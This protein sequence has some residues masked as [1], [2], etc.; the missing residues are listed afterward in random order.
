MIDNLSDFFTWRCQQQPAS[1]AYA[2]IRDDLAIAESLSYAELDAQVRTLAY[3][4]ARHSKPGDRVLL[5]YPPGL[6]FVRAFWACMLTGRIAV[7]VPAP[8]PVRFKNN[9]PRLRA[10]I[11]DAQVSLVLTTSN[12]LESAKSFDDDAGG[13][14]ADWLATDVAALP[15]HDREAANVALGPDSVAYLQYT[16][17]STSTPRGVIITHAQLLAQCQS[18]AWQIRAG[19]S[20]VLSWLPHFHD[21]GLVFGSLMPFHAGVPSTLMSPLSFL[22]RPLRWLEAMARHGATH[23]GAPNFAYMACVKALEQQPHWRADLRALLSCSC[24]AE[25]IHPDAAAQFHAAFRPHGLGDAVFAPAYGM[26]ETVLVITATPPGVPPVTLSLNAERLEQGIVAEGVEAAG[27]VRRVV[28]CGSPIPQMSACIVDPQTLAPSA[29]DRIGEIWVQG[30]SVGQGYWRR[31]SLSAEIFQARTVDGDG[32]Y[33]RTGDMGFMHEGQLFVSSRLKDLII[34]HGRNHAPH[35]IEW[36]V[37]RSNRVLRAGYGAAFSIDS[38]DGEALVVVQEVERSAVDAD[39]AQLIHAIRRAVAEEHDLPVHAVA[40]IRAGTVPRTSSGKIRRQVCKQEYLEAKLQTLLLD[41]TQTQ[42]AQSDPAAEFPADLRAQTDATVRLAAIQQTLLRLVARF[43]RRD[44]REISLDASAIECGLDSL[45]TFRLLQAIESSLGLALPPASVLGEPSLRG[46]AASIDTL[47]G[48]PVHAAPALH[49]GPSEQGAQ[50]LAAAQQRMWF[51]QEMAPDTA[52]YNVPLALALHGPLDAAVLQECLRD[53]TQ[54][55]PILCSRWVRVDGKAMQRVEATAHWSM[56]QV[57]LQGVDAAIAQFEQLAADEGLCALD[58][59]RE[60]PMRATLIRL[61]EDEHRLL[62]TLHHSVCDGWSIDLL[63]EEL[64]EL[65]SARIAR[66]AARLPQLALSYLDYAR[67]EPQWLDSGVREREL[68]YWTRKLAGVP[69]LLHLPADRRRSAVQR[70]R[71]A[72][73]PLTLAAAQ[74]RALRELALRTGTTL[75]MTLLASWQILMHRYSGQ[76]TIV[77]GSVVANRERPDLAGVVG[78]FANTLALRSD[79]GESMSVVDL[80][81]QVKANAL[82]AIDHQHLPFEEVIEALKLPRDTSRM[83][84]IQTMVVLQAPAQPLPRWGEASV[85]RLAL[86]SPI[87]KFDLTLELQEQGAALGGHISFDSDLFDAATV[88]RLA[89]HWLM[90][91]E[92]MCADASQNVATL[93]LL[94][95]AERERILALAH[96]D[97][98]TEMRFV[99]LQRCFEQ[100]AQRTPCAVAALFDDR[101]ASYQEL[102]AQSNRLAHELRRLGVGPDVRVGI[103]M[104]RS[105]ELVAALLGVLKAGGAFVPIDPE[106]PRDRVEF[107]LRD[108]AAPLLLTQSHLL[109]RVPQAGSGA[110]RQ[111]L[112]LDE[113]AVVLTKGITSDPDRES[114][115]HDLAYVIYTSGS[116]G[117]PKGVLIEHAAMH[118]SCRWMCDRLGLQP[119]DRMLAASSISF[120]ASVVEM[121]HPLRAGASVVLARAGAQRDTRALAQ[122]L[123]QQGVTT[124]VMVPSAL[125]A[126][127][128]EASF[129]PARLRFLI[130]AGEALDQTLARALQARLP[131]TTIGNFYGPTEASIVAT[132]CEWPIDCA[133]SAQV[134]IGRPIANAHCLVLDAHLQPVPIGVVGELYIGGAGLARGYL[135]QPAL[136]AERFI[137]HP[138][139]AGQ[140]LYRSGDLARYRSDANIEYLGR[141]DSQ[142]KIRGFRI[143]L[144]EIEAA[145]ATID[146]IREVVVVA[147]EDRPGD[148][149]LVA[150]LVGSG[151]DIQDLRRRLRATLPESMLPAAFVELAEL[152]TLTNGKINRHALPAPEF[153]VRRAEIVAPRNSIERATWEV[154]RDVLQVQQFGVTD[155]FFELGGHSLLAM[156]LISRLRTQL[157]VDL[158]LRTLFDAPTVE[159]LA[160]AIE[161][162][163]GKFDPKALPPIARSPAGPNAPLSAAQQGLWFLDRLQGASARYHIVHALRLRGALDVPALENALQALAARHDSLRMDIVESGGVP[164]QRLRPDVPWALQQHDLRA[165]KPA[166]RESVLQKRL[167][168]FAEAPIALEQAPLARAAVFRLRA[169]E[170]VLALIIHHIV[171]DGWSLQIV[172]RELAAEYNAACASLPSPLEPLVLSWRDV[173]HWDNARRRQGALAPAL[174]YWRQQLRDLEPLRLPLEGISPERHDEPGPVVRTQV[175]GPLAERIEAL[176]RQHNATVFMVLLAAIKVLLMRRCGRDDI[177]VGTPVAGRDRRDFEPLVGLFVNTLVLRTDLGGNPTFEAL[178]G[179]VRSTVLDA[180]AHQELGFDQLVAELAPAREADRQPFFDVMVNSFG[181]WQGVPDMA[182]LTAEPVALPTAQPKFALTVY[183]QANPGAIELCMVARR[184]RFS[185]TALRGLL[186]QLSVLIE[187]VADQPARALRD[188]SMVT[189]SAQALLPDPRRVLALPP[190]VSVLQEFNAQ[191]RQAPA[192]IAVRSDQRAHDYGELQLKSALLARVLRRRGVQRGDVIAICGQRGFAIPAAMLAVL[193]CGAV[194]MILDPALPALRRRTMLAATGSRFLCLFDTEP[195]S[196]ALTEGIDTLQRIVLDPMLDELPGTACAELDDANEVPCAPDDPA[197][198]FFTSGSSGTPKAVLGRQRALSHFIAWQRTRFGVT[199][200]DRVSQLISL[201]FDP[202]LRD[203]FLPLTSGATLCMPSERDLLDPLAWLAQEGV[204]IAHTTPTVMQS[205]LQCSRSERAT[206]QLRWLFVAGEPLTD[207]LIAEWRGRCGSQG[208]IVNLYGPT[209]TTLARCFH[210]VGARPDAGVQPVG[211]ALPDSQALVVSAH[212]VMCGVGEPGEIVIRTPMRSLGYFGQP[213]ETARRFRPNPWRDDTSDLLYYSGDLG[214]YRS[215]GALEIL[216]RLDDQVKIR[217]VRVEPAEVMAELSRHASVRQC[218][219]LPRPGSD[220]QIQL[221]AYVVAA[222]GAAPDS[223]VLHAHLAALLPQA[224]LPSA[225]VWIAALPTLPNGKIDRQALPAPT[226]G[227][228]ADAGLV[229]PRSPV[230]RAVWEIWRSVLRIDSFGVTTR[231]FELGGHSLLATQVLARVRDILGVELELRALFEAP[232]IASQAAAVERLLGTA[233]P[234]RAPA[235]PAI[236]RQPRD[237]LL[238]SSYSQRRMWLVQQFN[239]KNAAYNM[240]FAM[241]LRGVL[242]REALIAALQH[243]IARHEVFRTTL[244]AVHGEPMQRIAAS[245]SVPVESIDLRFLVEAKRTA[246]ACSELQQRALLPYDLATGPLHRMTLLQLGETEHVFFWSIHHSIGDGWSTT[247]LMRELANIYAALLRGAEPTLPPKAIEFADYAAWQRRVFSGEV[248]GR[249]LAY[250]R[251]T[252]EGLAPLPLP[253][254][255]PRRAA[256]DGR[257]SRISGTISPKTLAAVKALA[258]QQGV[259]PFMALLACFQLLLARHCGV[260]DVAVGTPIA[261]RTQLA[262]ETLVGTLVNTVV[263]RTALGG[264]PSFVEL[265]Q[266]VRETALQAYA[267]QDLPFEALVE[268]LAIQRSDASAPLVQVLFNVLNPPA[269]PLGIEGLDCELFE[270]DSGTSQFDLALSIDTEMFGQARLSFSTE[271]FDSSTG[272]RL[273]AS[274]LR[275]LEQVVV[276]P[277][278]SIYSFDLVGDQARQLL[279]DWNSTA[280]PRPRAQTIHGLFEEQARRSPNRV[281]LRGSSGSLTYV[282]LQQRSNQLARLL[283]SRGIGRGALVG[284]C[285]ERSLDMVVALLAVLKAGAA[286]VPLDPAYPQDRLAMM[287]EDAQLALLITESDVRTPHWPHHKCLLLDMSTAAIAAQSGAA[288]DAEARFD[289]DASDP[290]YVI[291]T[292]G[293]T[294]TPKGVV[295]PHRAAVNFLASMAHEPGLQTRD[296]LLAVTTLSFDIAV[297]ELLLPLTVGAQVIL[298]TRTEAADGKALRGLLESGAVSVM[299]AT[300][301]TWRLLVDAGWRG[302][303]VFKALI[304]GESLPIDLAQQL[305]ARCGELWNMYGPTETTVWS[306]CWRVDSVEHG[307]S[308]GRPIANTQIHILD[309]QLQL[310]PIGVTGEIAIGGEGVAQGYLNRPELSAERFVGDPFSSALGARLYR[311]GDRGRWR[312]DGRLEHLGRQDEQVKVRGHRIELGEIEAHLRSHSEV[313]HS[314]V[315]AREDRPGDVRLVAY[316]VARN[317]MPPPAALREHLRSRLPEYML[318][319]HF[320]AIAAL[321]LLPNGKMNRQALPLPV[322]TLILPPA[323]DVPQTPLEQAVAQIWQELLG[324]SQ[325][326][327]RDNFFDLG[328][329]SLLATRAVAEIESRLGLKLNPRRLVFESLAQL[330]AEAD[331]PAETQY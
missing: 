56:K 13:T 277:T 11:V 135:N 317:A 253:A 223:A 205:W 131:D 71:G 294:G 27:A 193:R 126:L 309:A 181:Q 229:M 278:A 111:V 206:P 221:V 242:H 42:G 298:A 128:S 279:A 49:A 234:N 98:N 232:M 240:P 227:A 195:T 51:W 260:N 167:A 302:S 93:A 107:Q 231:F 6:E 249:Q 280:H 21:Y 55:H 136:S 75:F 252:L 315:I 327:L 226:A 78:Y 38:D 133:G 257:G 272:A 161:S 197:Y 175:T 159:L 176:A 72:S 120:D 297:L 207:S 1:L 318:P 113:D 114:E 31:E 143:E 108:T 275:L 328:G 2:F 171:C 296:V 121:L 174:A 185:T 324:V 16:S 95:S 204:S 196:D 287:C 129:A 224:Y 153:D 301:S 194:F 213:E 261:N 288:L 61:A 15:L 322:E 84:L 215:D 17:G 292:S 88:E 200:S 285:V 156:Q 178:L 202:L 233:T 87:A 116:T 73:L 281:G 109:P 46:V 270:F 76:S 44:P 125:R 62:W 150:Y 118:N 7:P 299:Q 239:P 81:A 80:L 18:D 33:L 228:G 259:T 192:R 32:P 54:R 67:W 154:W 254:D 268:E 271:L 291:Y 237:R 323:S 306:T 8:D 119:G 320:V 209:E 169:T 69:A 105:L 65:Y 115:P 282:E 295:V 97:P 29:G 102:N 311:T 265:L 85:E 203:V 307:I 208:Q 45:S 101:R 132:H 53:L 329:H 300:P 14:G 220:G 238:P 187:A 91:I 274:Y 305:L 241:R 251:R 5:V 256:H 140:R 244:V 63:L 142:V 189:A 293:S 273:L 70:F 137:A 247:I 146:A 312:H 86:A 255:R 304:G 141:I 164:V 147:R 184:D 103:C 284:L 179:R 64:S 290:A 313:A 163:D 139:A 82:G 106:L 23:T 303:S 201:S 60:A 269:A 321:P 326:G 199:P 9:A 170:H 39:L 47:L 267:H 149:R 214:R 152:P 123:R 124:L 325:V 19:A 235:W 57:D 59:A 25:P 68:V 77:T 28:G 198:L 99:S 266:R 122:L 148:K 216:G 30:S 26:A 37:Q 258:V 134:P 245:L 186:D 50:P 160:R 92:G 218:A 145:L 180:W 79:F 183:L 314:V 35:D 162:H 172:L 48:R 151:I 83:P 246:A 74:L 58:P 211:T 155:N 24:G 20:R 250:W 173:C 330:T 127:L 316:V 166:Q 289:A 262:A 10:I 308:I 331:I 89:R 90:L 263:M 3:E 210:I 217:G 130:S 52:L 157:Q 225:F 112:C 43:A 144:G 100:H 219:V 117:R 34:V 188:Y 182:G 66:R 319:Q 94:S 248:L 4:L 158:P 110:L 40:L 96:G 243:L 165:C 222:A 138:F 236:E 310:C 12:L 283:R 212:G 22:R 190:F 168:E 177:A 104:D 264:N 286:Y 191:A 36:T 41:V 276:T 230:E